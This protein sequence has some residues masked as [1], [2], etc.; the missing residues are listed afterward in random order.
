MVARDPRI[1]WPDG[2][3]ADDR[4]VYCVLGQWN[5]LPGFNSG[6]NLRR[7]LYLLIRVP[8]L[9]RRSPE[10]LRIRF[11]W[12][13]AATGPAAAQPCSHRNPSK[14]MGRISRHEFACKHPAQRLCAAP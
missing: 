6:V 2:I 5:R 10:A 12:G 13:P 11:R 7:P 4:Y 9:D 14:C 3:F 8:T 1:I